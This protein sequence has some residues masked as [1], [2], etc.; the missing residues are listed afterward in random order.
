MY[1]SMLMPMSLRTYLLKFL[2]VLQ[3]HLKLTLQDTHF[4]VGLLHHRLHI[5][6]NNIHEFKTEVI[7]SLHKTKRT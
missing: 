1:I 3:K 5:Y 2:T 7:G 4:S 6:I